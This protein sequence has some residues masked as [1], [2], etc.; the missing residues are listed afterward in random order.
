MIFR[1]HSNLLTRALSQ[2]PVVLLT[3]PRQAGKSTLAR[4]VWPHADYVTLDHPAQAS[5]ADGAPGEFLAAHP[6][7]AV[8]D[9]VQYAPGLLRHLKQ[10][11]DADRTPGQYLLTG[12]QLFGLMRGVG[13]SLAG[14]VAVLGLGTLSLEEVGVGAAPE[15]IDAFAWRGGFPELHARPELDRA[16]WYGSYVATYLERDVRAAMNIGNLRD[17]DRF[18]RA[19]ALRIGQLLNFSDLARDVGVSPNTIKSWTSILQASGLVILLEPWHRQQTKRLIKTPRLYWADTGLALHLLAFRSREDVALHP[20]RGAIWENLV[21]SEVH[22][23]A[24]QQ[25]LPPPLWSWRTVHGEE[26]DLL[27]ETAPGRFVAIECKAAE[28]PGT[29]AL[30]GIRAL[31]V[32]QGAESIVAAR[33][34]ARTR[35]R[36]PLGSEGWVVPLAGPGGLLADLSSI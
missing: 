7:P 21:V 26:V 28:H 22:K 25:A 15:E 9:E 24:A 32:D 31:A 34:V 8:I 33:V 2:F 27:V 16:L 11:I 12:S 13:E 30:R 23:W 36:Y 29:D 5:L 20:L 14:R 6:P 1:H 19:A 4:L 18:L 3:G 35:Q 10:R 17:F